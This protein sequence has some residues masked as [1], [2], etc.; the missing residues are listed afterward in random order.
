MNHHQLQQQYY[1]WSQDA[2]SHELVPDQLPMKRMSRYDQFQKSHGHFLQEKYS[3]KY[4]HNDPDPEN[5]SFYR[6][7]FYADNIGGK[8]PKQP[9]HEES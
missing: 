5:Q 8:H 2:L 3:Q 7:T 6:L 1:Q 4:P 9:C